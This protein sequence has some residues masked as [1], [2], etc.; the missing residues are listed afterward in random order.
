MALVVTASISGCIGASDE[1]DG[2]NDNGLVL[3][4]PVLGAASGLPREP[5]QPASLDGPP[6]PVLGR[7]WSYDVDNL[8]LGSSFSVTTVVAGL[9]VGEV[10]V[11]MDADQVVDEAFVLH[12]PGVGQV[13]RDTLA[14]DAHGILILGLEFPLEEGKQWST[15]WY[16]G[17]DMTMSVDRVDGMKAELSFDHPN[18]DSSLVY[19][20]EAANIV[21]LSIP[22]Y[23]K[24]ELQDHGVG[25][26]GDV[27]VPYGVDL[28][29]CHGRVAGGLV[30]EDCAEGTA[31]PPVEAIPIEGDFDR[32][33][34]GL[35]VF[36][37]GEAPVGAGIFS[38]EVVAPD[39]QEY[40][41]E[42][43]PDQ[44]GNTGVIFGHDD[45]VGDW[46]MTAVAVG[47]GAVLFEGAAYQVFN[48]T[49]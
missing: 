39:G 13:K 1:E 44:A 38:L 31:G 48:V 10:L 21:S 3:D 7:W 4:G 35:I 46:E 49:L 36:D 32:F 42:K 8:L 27:M 25:F 24:M 45:P 26:E 12:L 14:F 19:D 41:I 18:G 16:G 23:A 11:G 9:D 33:S 15:K 2:S 40:R 47:V 20:A 30:I 22:G 6:E 5:T 28:V 34:F 37:L 29:V 17:Q 43:T